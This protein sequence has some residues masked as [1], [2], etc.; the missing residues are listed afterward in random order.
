MGLLRRDD[1]TLWLLVHTMTIT[2]VDYQ[3]RAQFVHAVLGG[4]LGTRLL[5]RRV[6]MTVRPK[7]QKTKA[8]SL[9]APSLRVLMKRN[10]ASI[11][12]HVRTMQV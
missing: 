5:A 1:S 8:C 10:S 2:E 4:F 9:N 11:K 3:V 6:R 12:H 7:A